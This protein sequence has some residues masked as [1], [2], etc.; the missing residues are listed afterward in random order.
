MIMM[1]ANQGFLLMSIKNARIDDVESPNRARFN[2]AC[3]GGLRREVNVR[4]YSE[5]RPCSHQRTCTTKLARVRTNARVSFNRKQESA[6]DPGGKE[7]RN[8]VNTIFCLCFYSYFCYCS[9]LFIRQSLST[10][11]LLCFLF[12]SLIF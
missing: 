1:S 3:A 8:T 4:A 9:F 12:F 11:L 2:D 7:Y 10:Y 6:D 5:E